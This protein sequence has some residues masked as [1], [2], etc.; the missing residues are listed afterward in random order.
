LTDLCEDSAFAMDS[1]WWDRP[2]YEPY[3]RRRLGLIGDAEYDYTAKV[4]LPQQV[5]Y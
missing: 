3:P 2:A 5:P 4:Y 1:E